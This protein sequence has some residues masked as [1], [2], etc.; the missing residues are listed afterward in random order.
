LKNHSIK[1]PFT[2]ENSELKVLPEV[3]Q[4]KRQFL[5]GLTALMGTAAVSQFISGDALSV[6]FSYQPTNNNTVVAGKLF[7]LKQMKVLH[8][9][10]AVVLPKTDTPSA[11][12]LDVHGFLDH[13]LSVCFD[14]EQQQQ[15]VD[16]V[17]KVNS[18]S[19]GHFSKEFIELSGT[20]QSNMLVALEAEKL[21]FTAQD[22][23][24][25]KSL[26]SLLVF[27]F[28]TTEIGATQALNYQAVPGGFKGSV[29]Y[30]SLKKSWGS[31]AYY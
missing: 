7:S 8:D 20:K 6:A 22:K 19:N 18:Q 25:F 31:L 26:K 14:K 5:R 11:A 3:E 23:Q 29:A 16:I 24:A 13:Q 30:S 4:S 27:G 21:G 12:E 10:C 17:E 9:I 15:A 28:F 1:Q 2:T